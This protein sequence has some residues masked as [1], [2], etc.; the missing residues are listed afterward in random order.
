MS[1]VSTILFWFK[2]YISCISMILT[3]LKKFAIHSLTCR[4]R[5]AQI[6]LMNLIRQ[7]RTEQTCA[8]SKWFLVT[9]KCI[10]FFFCSHYMDVRRK[11]AWIKHDQYLFFSVLLVEVSRMFD[12]HYI[13][14]ILP[15]LFR[16]VPEYKWAV[17]RWDVWMFCKSVYNEM[18]MLPS[19]S[20]HIREEKKES[21]KKF[22]Q[23]K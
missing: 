5:I 6:I 11:G 7:I 22:N 15:R 14:K 21:K 13:V 20:C 16:I 9:S 2:T 10:F 19:H 18:Q 12:W 1:R 17:G 8:A 3:T 4:R 23:K